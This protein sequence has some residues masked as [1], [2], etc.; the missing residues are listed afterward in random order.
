[1]KGLTVGSRCAAALVMFVALPGCMQSRVEESREL[2]TKIQSDEAVVILAKPQIEGAATEDGFMNCVGHALAGNGAGAISVRSNVEFVDS[3]FPWFEPGTAPM[4]PEAVATLLTRPG[5][6]ERVAQSGVRY[7]VWLDGG[8][9]KTDGGGSIAC[10]AAPGAAGCIGFG[11]WENESNYE[12]TVWDL[13]QAKSAGSVD[14]NVTG[15]SAII[16]AVVPLPFIARVQNLACNRMAGQLR[17]FFTGSDDAD[18]VQPTLNASNGKPK[19]TAVRA[20]TLAAKPTKVT[21]AVN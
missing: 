13:K 10:G 2:H 19:T 9:Q 4:R 8:T 20:A 7:I 12:A 21:S 1:M 17:S 3:M 5:V 11:W 14:T 18:T 16:G 15:T 6:S